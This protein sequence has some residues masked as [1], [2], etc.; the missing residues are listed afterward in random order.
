LAWQDN[1]G[2]AESGFK[3]ERSLDGSTNW[4]E[5]GST[6][7]NVAI[8]QDTGL[9][10]STTYYYR[11]RAYSSTTTSAYSNTTNGTTP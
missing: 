7:A 3:V 4:T 11:V 1:S 10:P 5:V 6:G 8:Y 2:G 9:A